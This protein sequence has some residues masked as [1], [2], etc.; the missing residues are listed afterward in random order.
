MY[1]PFKMKGKSPMMKA[2][3]GKQNNLPEQLKAKILASPESPAKMKK[4]SAMKHEPWAKKHKERPAHSGT[5]EAHNASPAKMMGKDPSKKKTKMLKG[6]TIF[7]KEV[8]KKNVKRA[9]NAVATGGMSEVARKAAKTKVGKKVIKGVKK[10]YN[11]VKEAANS[12]AL[13]AGG[14]RK[15]KVKAK[16]VKKG[17]TKGAISRAR[18]IGNTTAVAQGAGRKVKAKLTKSTTKPKPSNKTTG[19]RKVKNGGLSDEMAKNHTLRNKLVD[20][21]TPATERDDGTTKTQGRGTLIGNQRARQQRNK[22]RFL[23]K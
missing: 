21:F 6:T 3:I 19:K 8:N 20:K 1:T 17:A 22:K 4:A 16:A 18:A 9:V 10:V 13:Q 5:A 15:K 23:K 2:L 14:P 12:G 7:G 11:K